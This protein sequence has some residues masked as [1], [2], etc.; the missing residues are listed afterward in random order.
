MYP[1]LMII[2]QFSITSAQYSKEDLN[3]E[4][5]HIYITRNVANEIR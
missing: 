5:L 1:L 4:I 3:L 2:V